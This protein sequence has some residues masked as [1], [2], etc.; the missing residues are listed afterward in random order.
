MAHPANIGQTREPVALRLLKGRNG[1]DTGHDVIDSPPPFA[2]NEPEKPHD[3]SPDASSA[4]DLIVTQ[5]R[6]LPVG[7]KKLD[8]PALVAA[9]ET[10]ARWLEAVRFRRQKGV[11]APTIDGGIIVAPWVRVEEAASREWRAWCAE[12][13]LT[14]AAESNLPAMPSPDGAQT[15]PFE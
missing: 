11:L 13:G 12:F 15:N 6:S 1:R 7:M 14:P 10:Y 9:C 3:L 2:R 5:Y 8:G 4:W